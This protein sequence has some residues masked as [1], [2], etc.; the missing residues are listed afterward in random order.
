MLD[1]CSDPPFSTSPKPLA[2]SKNGHWSTIT[3][4]KAIATTSS[5]LTWAATSLFS[6]GSLAC[7]FGF[8]IDDANRLKVLT[9]SEYSGEKYISFQADWYIQTRYISSL[10]T[11]SSQFVDMLV[12]A[13]K[14]SYHQFPTS[15]RSEQPGNTKRDSLHYWNPQ[16]EQRKLGST[17]TAMCTLGPIFGIQVLCTLRLAGVWVIHHHLQHSAHICL[18]PAS[19]YSSSALKDLVNS[20]KFKRNH[21]W[22]VR[23]KSKM[24]PVILL[25]PEGQLRFEAQPCTSLQTYLPAGRERPSTEVWQNPACKQGKAFERILSCNCKESRIPEADLAS[26]TSPP[27]SNTMPTFYRESPIPKPRKDEI[28]S[29]QLIRIIFHIYI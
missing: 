23:H 15:Q 10:I 21:Q 3:L 9:V 5:I 2:L 12:Y 25:L 4:E 19:K 22:Q 11:L 27:D 8:A 7:C 17:H 29:S 26:Y 1:K 6:L 14:S 18:P 24:T 13:K 16:F 28:L 20:S